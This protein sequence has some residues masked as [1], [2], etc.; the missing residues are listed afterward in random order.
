MALSYTEHQLKQAL[1]FLS[2]H[3]NPDLL[4]L[5]SFDCPNS[6]IGDL[7]HVSNKAIK[8]NHMEVLFWAK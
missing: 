7:F 8:I 4:K 2:L 5:L 6:D 1:G 3:K